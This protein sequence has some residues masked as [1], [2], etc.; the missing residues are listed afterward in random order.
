MGTSHA[1][2]SASEVPTPKQMSEFWR[3]VTCGRITKRKLQAFL[4]DGKTPNNEELARQ[5][6]GDDIV[7]PEDI[8]AAGGL[9]YADE[10]LQ[11][12]IDTIPSEEALRELKANNFALVAGPSKP[13]SLLEVR[14]ADSGPF[15][16][17]TEGWYSN[18]NEKFA[19]NDRAPTEW[20]AIRKEP[21]LNSTNRRWNE[22]LGLIS[23]NERVPNA[24]EMSWFIT[25][26]FKV[27]GVRLFASVYARTSSVDSSG[28]RVCVGGF[29]ADGL[30]VSSGWGDGRGSGLGVAS[31]RKF[32]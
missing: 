9:F 15:Y 4:R 24:G 26:Y 11:R 31:A 8:A 5:I 13:M 20:L 22:Q 25:T 32:N 12:F 14:D 19:M 7:F 16:T 1:V 18:V 27:R 28:V 23:V 6:L 10:Q 21:V 2:A 17:K 3:Q 29:G 30:C